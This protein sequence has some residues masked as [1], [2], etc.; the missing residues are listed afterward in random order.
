MIFLYALEIDSEL[1]SIPVHILPSNQ[2]C[3]DNNIVSKV[4]TSKPISEGVSQADF[5]KLIGYIETSRPLWNH[6]MSLG[7]RSESIKRNLWNQ[8]FVN[9]EGKLCKTSIYVICI[10]IVI[11]L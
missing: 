2:N 10:F 5:S 11:E 8:I 4:D 1:N 9:F 7:E 6:K 3:I